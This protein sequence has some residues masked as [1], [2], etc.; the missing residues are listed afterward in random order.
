MDIKK[1]FVFLL[2]GIFLISFVSAFEFDNVKSY[3]AVK[4]E[5]TITNVYGLGSDI[6]KA[7]LNTPLNVKVGA[8]Y[9]KVAEFDISTYQD[10][11]DGLKDFTFIDMNTGKTL[12]QDIDI[13][14]LTYEE[15]SIDDYK[16]VKVEIYKNETISYEQIKVGSH[17]EKRKVWKPLTSDFKKDQTITIGLF[18]N[19]K[20]GDYVDWIPTIYGVEVKEWATW[21]GDMDIDLNVYYKLNASSGDVVNEVGTNGVEGAN[22]PTRNVVGKIE[23]AFDFDGSDDYVDTNYQIS[24]VAGD[25][26]VNLWIKTTT[27]AV[28][29]LLSAYDGVRQT[30]FGRLNSGATGQLDMIMASTG[31]TYL[32]LTTDDWRDGN[33][34]MITF[35]QGGT[36]EEDMSI[37]IDGVNQTVT[38]VEGGTLS[39]AGMTNDLFL[40]TSDFSGTPTYFFDGSIDEVG[41]WDRA[42]S[43]DEI[44][45]L[46]N[47]G[48]GRTYGDDGLSETPHIILNSPTVDTNYTTT[49]TIT[50]NFTAWDD[51]EL[52]DV[53]IYVNDA[54][55]QTNA[56]GINNTNYLFDIDFGDGEFEV[57][58]IAT[59][60]ESQTNQSASV[61]FVIDSTTP[62]IS[63][64]SNLTDLTTFTIPINST[65]NYTAMDTHLD[66]CY[67][68]T[69][70]NETQTVETCNASIT[71]T[72]ET[73][74]NKTIQYCANDTFGFETCNT[75]YIYIYYIQET[76]AENPN[77]IAESF[78]A[79]FNLTINLTNIPTTTA[80]LVLN[81][82]VY[83]PTTTTAGTNGY[84][85]EV[86]VPIPD[87][88]GNTT[89]ITQD[90][91]WNYTIA[92]V[93]TDEIT[94]TE[95]ITVYELGVDDCSSYGE[96][97]FD[98]SILDEK[99]L[100]LANESETITVEADLILTSKED[101]T[102]SISYSNTWDADNNPQICVP[103][104]VINNSQYWID[105][106]VGL[107]S[108]DHVSEFFYMDSGTLNSTKTY[109]NFNGKTNQSIDLMDLLTADSTSFLFNYFD[110]DGLAVDGSIVHVMRK[111][112]GEGKFREVERAKQDQN[113]DTIV[114]L[115]EEDV[116]YYFMITKD[117]ILLYTSS[118]YTALCQA[119][120]CTIQIEA[121]GGSATFPT[122]WDLIDGGAYD[123]SSDASTRD[124][125]LTYSFNESDTINLTVYKY[126]SD[127][128]YSAIVT[129]S[130]TGTT[131]SIDLYVP[132]SAGNVS[133]FATVI[134]G[135]DFKN[136]EWIN[137]ESTPQDI[138]G[139]TLSLFLAGLIILTL[140]LFAIHEG[141]GTIAYIILGI[142]I[143]GALGLLNTTLSTGV[144]IVI[145]LVLAGGIFIW[146]LT[147]G[148]T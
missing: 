43:T 7:R 98:F 41:F 55:N 45:F 85:F 1:L 3:D 144:N 75:D 91:F 40:G 50:F 89:G 86:T 19:V 12:N 104:G 65:W 26:T 20:L 18:T 103:S 51:I 82:T 71:T 122:N 94:D 53:K 77:P 32:T 8:G 78:D 147:R 125:T 118:T 47:D 88:W 135:G 102:Q 72:W 14:Y 24:D 42:L 35:L 87:G 22:P 93:I 120:P 79:T 48:D 121:S 36:T 83:A 57:Y 23:K 148:R 80:N 143:S 37:W 139:V 130:S 56:S 137:F 2:M 28:S 119:T 114:H 97:I 17:K 81:N 54:L 39:S 129:N 52:S 115:V 60:N 66:Q 131:G 109:E 31:S 112:I 105:L 30:Y 128:S 64:A 49:Q 63:N 29:H 136:S 99:T 90:W 110:A 106:T 95:N 27:T 100:V 141:A 134:K 127:G 113:G 34:H 68:N 33:W 44:G 73:G 16:S 132:Q 5:V 58:G 133:F 107:S 111:Y 67:Y 142:I 124:V 92:G 38:R 146:K 108:T 74:G 116:I 84:Y 15:V 69:S 61:N 9:Q 62:T 96:V 123:I 138:F 25:K 21:S 46:W 145:Y 6:G 11:S 117:G 126:N 101:A 10:Y 140:G 4:R 59:N 76:Q 13:K 70:D